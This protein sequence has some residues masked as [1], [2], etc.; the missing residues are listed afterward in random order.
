MMNILRLTLIG[1]ISIN[2]AWS[3]APKSYNQAKPYVYALFR[4][5]P[6]T[7]YCHCRYEHKKINLNSCNMQS[8]AHLA[9]AHRVELEHMMPAE[10]FGRQLACWREKICIKNNKAYRGRKCCRQQ[11]PLFNQA[12]GELYNLW[13]SVGLV[14]GARSNF[15]YNAFKGSAFYGCPIV[16]DKTHRQVSP[17]D[18]VKGI[19]ARANLFMSDEYHIVLSSAQRRLFLAWHKQFPPDDWEKQWAAAVEKIEGYRNPYIQ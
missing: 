12:E 1:L 3:A 14:N 13:P 18:E 16:I 7:L 4:E 9:R 17:A 11:S 2:S 19:V 8:A 5:H 15:R 10:N 6:I